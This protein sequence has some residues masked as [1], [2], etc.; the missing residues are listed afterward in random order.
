MTLQLYSMVLIVS[1]ELAHCTS[2]LYF[3]FGSP[4]AMT[5]GLGELGSVECHRAVV[6]ITQREVGR[7]LPRQST[8]GFSQ[9]LL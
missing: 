1:S 3:M 8:P 4:H 2:N 9:Q 5:A 6:G 7:A